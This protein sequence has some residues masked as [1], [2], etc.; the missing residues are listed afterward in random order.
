L[1]AGRAS[2]EVKREIAPVTC[3]IPECNTDPIGDTVADVDDIG[4]RQAV[5]PLALGAA[6][7]Q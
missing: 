5:H 1:G 2:V 6:P 7:E 3:A 4:E